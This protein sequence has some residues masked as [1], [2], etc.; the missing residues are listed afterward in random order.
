[1]TTMIFVSKFAIPLVLKKN[2]FKYKPQKQQNLCIVI[3]KVQFNIS[4]KREN[5]DLK[6]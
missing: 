3:W 4:F 5:D 1:M 6:A 2:Y